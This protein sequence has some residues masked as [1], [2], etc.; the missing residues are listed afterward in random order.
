MGSGR[1]WPKKNA[2]N[3]RCRN[4]FLGV[5]GSP[6]ERHPAPVPR[7]TAL[8]TLFQEGFKNRTRGFAS[9]GHLLCS[10]GP[11][12]FHPVNKDTLKRNHILWFGY[13]QI[14]RLKVSF[15]NTTDSSDV[16]FL[17]NVFVPLFG[18]CKSIQGALRP[19]PH[20]Y[21]PPT[22]FISTPL[23]FLRASHRRDGPGYGPPAARGRLKPVAFPCCVAR[24]KGGGSTASFQRLLGPCVCA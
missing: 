7:R 15:G 1:Q 5:S 23:V 19:H 13:G 10:A 24:E 6:K 14:T 11:S 20:L 18:D 9:G 2:C 16:L 17:L 21:S 22:A 3:I 12:V 8:R 4:P